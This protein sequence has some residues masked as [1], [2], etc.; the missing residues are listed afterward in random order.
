MVSYKKWYTQR[1]VSSCRIKIFTPFRLLYEGF[2]AKQKQGV[3]Q[4]LPGCLQKFPAPALCKLGNQAPHRLRAGPHG[5]AGTGNKLTL[6]HF[7]VPLWP[8]VNQVTATQTE[9]GL[10]CLREFSLLLR[11]SPLKV[12]NVSRASQWPVMAC[13]KVSACLGK[14]RP[15]N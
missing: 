10:S 7:P 14:R 12:L 1:Q 6:L 15:D 2:P 5:H 13:V 3:L 9:G 4:E 11:I 8:S